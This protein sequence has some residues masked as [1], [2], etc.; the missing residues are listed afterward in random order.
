MANLSEFSQAV[1]NALNGKSTLT[2]S[3][4]L[5]VATASSFGFEI[6]ELGELVGIAETKY[7]VSIVS[8]EKLF[9]VI[10]RIN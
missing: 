1:V 7:T 9:D 2:I 8:E 3:D 4:D 5:D 6:N 10:P